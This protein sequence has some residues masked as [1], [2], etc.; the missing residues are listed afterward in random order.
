MVSKS[1]AAGYDCFFSGTVDILQATC[2]S[3]PVER[4]KRI[5]PVCVKRKCRTIR[6]DQNG[7][8]KTIQG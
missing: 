8:F 2:Y 1:F 7:F 5:F 4:D 6:T 3:Q